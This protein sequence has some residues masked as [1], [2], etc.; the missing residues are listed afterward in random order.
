MP[1]LKASQQGLTQIRRA[2]S[3]KGWKIGSDRW[4]VEASKLL[5]PHGDWRADGPYAY[6]CSLQTW[7]R[8]LYG[9][10]IRDRSFK[11]FCEVLGVDPK[12]VAE[13]PHRLREDWG[14][15]PDTPVFYGRQQELQTLERWIFEEQCRL[16]SIVGLAGIGKT[17]LV[18]GGIGKTDQALPL[19]QRVRR[20]FTHLIWRRLINAPPPE[21]ILAELIDFVSDGQVTDLSATPEGLTTQ[22]LDYLKRRRCLVVIDNVESILQGGDRAGDYR[23]GYEPYG[24]LF[25]RIGESEH[26]SCVLLTSREKPQDIEAMEGLLSVRSL[27]LGGLD[28]TAGRALF[29]DI[30][31]VYHSMFQGGDDEWSALVS[32]YSGNPL[33]LEVAARHIL[34]RFSGDISKFL[35]QQFTVLGQICQVLDWHFERLSEAEKEILYWL[36]INREPVSIADLKD[37]ILSPLAQKHV[38]ETLDTLE[39]QIPLEKNG[40]RV[41]VQPVL[42]EY[43]TDRFVDQI[44]QELNTGHLQLF[45]RHALI[46]AST[47][48]HIKASQTRVILP[49]VIERL[50]AGFDQQEPGL[51]K[52]LLKIG[53]ILKQAYQ[54]RPGYATG[55]L[56]NVLQRSGVDM[57]RYDFPNLA[58][59]Q[60]DL[61]GA[62]LHHVNFK[63]CEFAKSSFTQPFGGVHAIAFSPDRNLLAMGD[64]NG[65]IRLFH[66]HDRQPQLCFRSQDKSAWVTSMAF[67]P[68][69]EWLVSSSL[70]RTV[71]LWNAHTGECV[72]TFDR[73]SKWVWT[74]AFSPDGQTVASGGDDGAIRLWNIHTGDCQVLEGHPGGVWSVAFDPSGHILASGGC[75]HTIRFWNSNTGDCFKVLSGHHNSIWSIAFHPNGTMLASG[76]VDD[77]VKVWDAQ[78]GACLNTLNGH[79]KEVRS[80]AFSGDGHFLASGSFDQTIRVWDVQTGKLARTLKG[81]ANG[82]RTVTIDPAANILASGD[83][84]QVLKLWDVQTG[85]CLKTWQGYANWMWTIAISPDGQWLASGSLD[86]SIRLWDRHTGA[87]IT[88]LQGHRNWV[89][90]VAFS[91][92]GQTLASG[93]D[94]ETIKLWDVKTG[95]C[96]QTLRGYAKGGV[97]SVTFSPNGRWL[98]SGG[99]DGTIRFWDA[100]TGEPLQCLAGHANW[101][102]AV[103]FSPEGRYLASCS[104]DQTI[105]LWDVTTGDCCL[106]I[107]DT[108]AKVMTIAFSSNGQTLVSGGDDGQVKLWDVGAGE[109]IQTF[110]G[111]TDSILA[112]AVSPDGRLISSASAD[113]T[114]RLWQGR[115]GHC[116]RVLKGHRAW[117]RA[118]V[119]TPEGQTLASSSTD[120]VIQLWNVETG[121]SL[122]QLR[123]NRP[124]EGM[125]INGVKGLTAAQEEA[126]MVLGA[127]NVEVETA[128][129]LNL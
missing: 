38:P 73:H 31:G 58:I 50:I 83:N 16:I 84:Y 59:W 3:Q 96:R 71:K 92:D 67:S 43:I 34:R 89:W 49:P 15:A 77:T 68:H 76:S 125:N 88:E 64:S 93:S 91:P 104:E 108:L 123:P 97:W 60:A 45:N 79:T 119:F 47:K 56:L 75:D 18:R 26:Q 66:L 37:D 90:S 128:L 69:G 35:A 102:W 8:F 124:Y 19:A 2:I 21:A 25:R 52:Q 115:T 110:Q 42:L 41:T 20:D 112:V 62:Q 109:C 30:G 22:L 72:E 11:A 5:E 4:L 63:G 14:E 24:D 13:F 122:R 55:N 61:Q 121:Q 118:I 28:I 101:V 94:D 107:Q 10:A 53:S 80:V 114:I 12:T 106:S 70:D 7:E 46:K 100:A 105:K 98:A 113:G 57:S 120:G 99:S 40:D 86:Q 17:R 36:A 85:E 78:T 6:G 54:H 44:C 33:A 65:E 127:T 81:H 39:R 111:H 95:E 82:V 48:D 1:S 87:L 116:V 32:F 103:T 129:A 117:V 9:T 27:T 51:E 74:V 23:A 126:L 29:Q